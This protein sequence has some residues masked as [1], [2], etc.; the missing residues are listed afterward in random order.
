MSR[1]L[2]DAVLWLGIVLYQNVPR[3]LERLCAALRLNQETPGTPAFRVV[4]WDN[5][6]TDALRAELSRLAPGSDYRFAGANLGF[7]AAH[8][9]V[10][11]EAFA[12]PTTRYY[13][14]VNPDGVPH[15]RCLSELVTEA[16]RAE[17]TGLIEARLFPDEHPKPYEPVTH[18]TPWCSGCVLLLTRELYR[19]VGGFD[20]RFFMYC[21]DVDLSWRARAA[22]FSIRVAPRALVH[23]YTVDREI[24][25]RRELSV[26]RSAALLGAKYGN[27]AFARERLREYQALGGEPFSLP[28]VARP[29]AAMARVADFRHLFMFAESRW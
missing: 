18:E 20:E 19:Q 16:E 27:A 22:G 1:D 17:R 7:G 5:S 2:D 14:C 23:H 9:R 3:E 8:N 26:R 13:L 25:T 4:W 24:T 11:K 28:A 21:E 6:P 15:P 10:M 29:P 12:S